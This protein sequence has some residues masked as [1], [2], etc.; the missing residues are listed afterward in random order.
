MKSDLSEPILPGSLLNLWSSDSHP[1]G[2][3]TNTFP[4][5]YFDAI[6]DM[7]TNVKWEA[8]KGFTHRTLKLNEIYRDKAGQSVD[9]AMH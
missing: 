9:T 3:H 8:G 7:N 2:K 1:A 5:F 4:M 6:P